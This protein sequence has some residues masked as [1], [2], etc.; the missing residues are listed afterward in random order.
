MG[1]AMLGRKSSSCSLAML[2]T[3]MNSASTSFI[4][5]RAALRCPLPPSMSTRSGMMAHVLP[6]WDA[7]LKRRLS[8]SW[9][10]A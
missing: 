4:A 10:M 8:T 5:A 3:G 6:S 1:S 2:A 7:C 9:I